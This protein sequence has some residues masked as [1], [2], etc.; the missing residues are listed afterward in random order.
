MVYVSSLAV[1]F[2]VHVLAALSMGWAFGYERYFHGRAAGTQIYCLV[3][4]AS[5]ALTFAVGYPSLWYGGTVHTADVNPLPLI[6]SILT[7]IGF[8][9]AG[10]IVK[11]GTSIRGLTTA[12]SIWSSA[13]I[14]ILVGLG[15]VGGA[16]ALTLLYI[17]C[18]ASLPRLEHLLPGHAT[19]AVVLRYRENYTPHEDVVTAFLAERGLS[20][21]AGSLSVGYDARGFELQLTIISSSTAQASTLSRVADELTHLPYVESFTIAQTS[22]G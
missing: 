20:I 5:C 15:F 11:S 9:G 8:L 6:G 2:V 7:G 12:A 4:M 21:M 3:C 16:A 1:D 19:L 13:A 22:R 14:G 18:M 17:I 10:L